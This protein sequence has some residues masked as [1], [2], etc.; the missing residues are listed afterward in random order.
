MKLVVMTDYKSINHKYHKKKNKKNKNKKKIKKLG[1]IQ[2]NETMQ[3]IMMIFLLPFSHT[4]PLSRLSPHRT[5][6]HEVQ[7]EDQHDNGNSHFQ[8]VFDLLMAMC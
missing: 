7:V 5:I 4:H 6:H 3:I 8:I 2:S 1:S